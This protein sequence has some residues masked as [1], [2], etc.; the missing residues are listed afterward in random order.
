M[1]RGTSSEPDGKT[2][3]PTLRTAAAQKAHAANI[4][5]GFRE[6]AALP[7]LDGRPTLEILSELRGTDDSMA[8]SSG[9]S[10]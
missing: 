5:E 8:T 10:T 4:L 2:E 6:I 7:S 1:N 9:E 3:G